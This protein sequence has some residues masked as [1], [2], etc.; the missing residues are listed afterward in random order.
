MKTAF[1][2]TVGTMIAAAALG[3]P[4]L[5]RWEKAH[6]FPFGQMCNSIFT[7]WVDTCPRGTQNSTEIGRL[8]RGR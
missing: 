7:G 4:N 8:I 2:V 5:S 1:V 6:K 3:Y